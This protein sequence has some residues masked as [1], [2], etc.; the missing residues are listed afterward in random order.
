ME[1]EVAKLIQEYTSY[2]VKS[3]FDD[4]IDDK[5]V[6]PITIKPYKTGNLLLPKGR[7]L[8]N[9]RKGSKNINGLTKT[10]KQKLFSTTQKIIQLMEEQNEK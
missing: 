4:M 3:I 10:Q 7:V 5:K 9:R 8:A 1:N 6:H 2:V